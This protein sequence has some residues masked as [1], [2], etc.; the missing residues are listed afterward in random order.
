MWA[1]VDSSLTAFDGKRAE[2]IG[3]QIR[4]VAA[5]RVSVVNT[6][7]WLPG[8][9]TM[10]TMRKPGDKKMECVGWWAEPKVQTTRRSAGSQDAT[11]VI[12]KSRLAQPAPLRDEREGLN[13][14]RPSKVHKVLHPPLQL[15]SFPIFRVIA[16]SHL[17]RW[18]AT[19]E[20]TSIGINTNLKFP[21]SLNSTFLLSPRTAYAARLTRC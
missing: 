1:I 21:V 2:T 5:S 15:I 4:K 18:R 11:H 16:L 3:V 19:R 10:E 12:G 20:A 14:K 6:K 13:F 17:Q 7:T 8:R 9:R